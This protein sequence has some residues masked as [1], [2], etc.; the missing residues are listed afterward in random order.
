M[1]DAR[2]LT[3][4]KKNA[5]LINVSRGP[6]IDEKA[7][8]AHCRRNPEFKVGLDV[9]EKE[10]TL[11]A[12]LAKL[13]NVTLLPHIGSATHWTREAMSTIAAHNVASILSGYPVWQGEDIGVFL[14]DNPPKAAPSIV[15]A[16]QLGLR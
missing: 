12:G 9:Y 16:M 15:N 2:R 4:M 6:V 11:S 10:P 8:V 13:R 14:K 7:L 3:L 1:I 5:I